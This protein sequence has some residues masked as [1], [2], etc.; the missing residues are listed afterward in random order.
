MIADIAGAAGGQQRVGQRM[1]GDI[2]IGM[3][4]ELLV[5]RNEDAAKRDAVARLELVH[6]IAVAGAHIRQQRSAKAFRRPWR[7]PV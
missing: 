3:A 5:V 6:V 7:Y 2:G 1:Q 4:L